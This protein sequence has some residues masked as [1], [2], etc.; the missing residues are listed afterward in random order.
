M[1]KLSDLFSRNDILKMISSIV[2]T[3]DTKMV[4]EKLQVFAGKGDD[5]K[6]ILSREFKI[7]EKQSRLSY[8]IEDIKLDQNGKPYLVASDGLGPNFEIHPKDFSKY[9]R[10]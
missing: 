8:T 7:R 5:R 10:A 2:S 4:E 3:N 9:E 6:T 1:L